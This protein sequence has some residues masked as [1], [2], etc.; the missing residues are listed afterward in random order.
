VVLSFTERWI[1]DA[2]ECDG[3]A[4]VVHDGNGVPSGVTT[5]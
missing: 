5:T 4:A 3:L 2:V 1:A